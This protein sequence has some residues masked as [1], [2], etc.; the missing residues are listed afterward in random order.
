VGDL[1]NIGCSYRTKGGGLKRCYTYTNTAG[2]PGALAR[3]TDTK[4]P[5]VSV[6]NASEQSLYMGPGIYLHSDGKLYIRLSALRHGVGAAQV[7]QSA[8]L[9]SDPPWNWSD[10]DPEDEDPNKVEMFIS[11]TNNQNRAGTSTNISYIL[12]INGTAGWTFENLDLV[13]GGNTIEMDQCGSSG[14]VFRGVRLLGYAP[15]NMQDTW[16]QSTV[17]QCHAVFEMKNTFDVLCERCEFWGATPPW[18]GWEE[19]KANFGAYPIAAMP[20]LWYQYNGTREVKDASIRFVNCLMEGFPEF[21]RQSGKLAYLK[22]HQCALKYCGF[23]GLLV[24]ET[25]RLD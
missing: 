21:T 10:D 7:D 20:I 4:Y 25:P 14:H 6:D 2:T 22:L 12:R 17:G 9:G 24:S 19:N 23:D 3:L 8:G 16:R 5:R 11:S 18:R 15:P 1:V 13:G